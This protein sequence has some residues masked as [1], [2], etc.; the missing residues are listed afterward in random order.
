M[1]V[2]AEAVKQLRERTGA[3]VLDCR[4]ALEETAGD[5]DKAA[6][7][8]RE[9]GQAAASKREGRETRDGMIDLY[10]HGEGRV[11]VMVE[12]NCE[13]DFVA[14]TEPFRRFAHEI[15]LQVAAHS[16]R[17]VRPEDVPP[18]ILEH[19]QRT[20][21]E[22]AIQEGKAEGIVDRIVEGRIEK[23]LDETCLMRQTYVRDDSKTIENL[24]QETIAA[25]GENITIRRFA[26]W[27][28]GEEIA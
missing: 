19:E 21:R 6:E 28:V 8:I 12:V 10:R 13:T 20:A 22:R 23:F 4:R 25:T 24:I 3:G 9:R 15:S 18:E 11:G 17:W 26:R 1:K 2:S 27:G 7:L 5:V 14:R 16:P